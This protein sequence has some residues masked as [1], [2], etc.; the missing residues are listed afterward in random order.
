MNSACPLSANSGHHALRSGRLFCC[1]FPYASA[2]RSIAWSQDK[3]V[4]VWRRNHQC[5]RDEVFASLGIR[6]SRILDKWV[7]SFHHRMRCDSL[8]VN[9]TRSSRDKLR[10]EGAQFGLLQS[11]ICQKSGLRSFSVCSKQ[12]TSRICD[13][14]VHNNVQQCAIHFQ[15]AI[16]IDETQFPEFVHEGNERR[17]HIVRFGPIADIREKGPAQTER[18][19]RGGLCEIRFRCLLRRKVHIHARWGSQ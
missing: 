8:K 18:P 1:E 17:G 12:N 13:L 5:I 6:P 19:P 16:V 7:G 4:K 14:V 9:M 15:A 11:A 2:L 10:P 3:H